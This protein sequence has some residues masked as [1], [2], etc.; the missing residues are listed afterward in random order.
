MRTRRLTDRGARPSFVDM[1]VTKPSRDI[2]EPLRTSEQVC[3]AVLR[4]RLMTY[5][6]DLM[7]VCD[8]SVRGRLF[9]DEEVL[10]IG[11]CADITTTGDIDSGGAGWTYVMVTNRRLHWVVDIARF[12]TACSLDHDDVWRCS[13]ALWRHRSAI[14]LGHD[15]LIRQHLVPNGRPLHWEYRAM[16]LVVGPLSETILAFSRPTAAAAE[17]L[18]EQLVHRGLKIGHVPQLNRVP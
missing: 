1:I 6:R 9:T 15:P 4:W 17:A 7:D 12:D 3:H 5:L 13:E 16:D 8:A 2:R 11:R 18:K 14:T 10:A